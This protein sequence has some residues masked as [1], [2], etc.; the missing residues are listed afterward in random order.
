MKH[1]MAVITLCSLII[2]ALVLVD[3]NAWSGCSIEQRIELGKQGYDKD[4]V[5]KTC[6][7]SGD[8]FWEILSRGLAT[9]L[10]NG[11]TNGLDRALGGTRN[12]YRNDASS[13]M[14]GASRCETN[15]GTCPLSGGPTGYPCY[16]PAWNGSTLMGISK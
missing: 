10:T 1:V 8:D 16:C 6:G 2:P 14:N 4:R 7:D 9:G 13:P 3:S 12:N 5:D 11:L 15:Y